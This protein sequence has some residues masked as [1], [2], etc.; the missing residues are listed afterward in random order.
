MER[1]APIIVTDST[2][3][4]L[5][6]HAEV[7]VLVDFH[8]P[9]CAPCRS[10]EPVIRTLA[11]RY[12]GAVRIARVDV[13]ASPE[14]ARLMGIRSV[15]SVALMFR[16]QVRDLLIGERPLE[17]YERIL[18]ALLWEDAAPGRNIRSDMMNGLVI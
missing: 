11:Q 8:A 2:F 12:T 6:T 15:P 18:D 5:V 16:G 9:W 7:P 14:I 10:L 3:E 4:A 17:D 13:D 1:D